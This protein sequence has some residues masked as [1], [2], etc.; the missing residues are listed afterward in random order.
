MKSTPLPRWRSRMEILLFEGQRRAGGIVGSLFSSSSSGNV[1]L[2]LALLVRFFHPLMLNLR[3]FLI[4][5]L[6]RA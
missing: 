3:D 6:L 2:L 1:D 5:S 4:I